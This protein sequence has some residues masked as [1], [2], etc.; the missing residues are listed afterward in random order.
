VMDRLRVD[1][2]K[3]KKAVYQR[4]DYESRVEKSVKT[5]RAGSHSLLFSFT[6]CHSEP[7]KAKSLPRARGI[8]HFV[9]N[10]IRLFNYASCSFFNISK[11]CLRNLITFGATT[12][13]Q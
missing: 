8:L 1:E 13:T 9:Q 10:D 11:K 12:A 6:R 4:G 2:Y 5:K 3:Y 7:C